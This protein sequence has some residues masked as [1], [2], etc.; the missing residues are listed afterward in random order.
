MFNRPICICCFPIQRKETESPGYSEKCEGC[1]CGK[2]M[3]WDLYDRIWSHPMRLFPAIPFYWLD[4]LIPHLS[5][6]MSNVFVFICFLDGSFGDEHVNTP[7][8]NRQPIERVQNW[9]HQKYS[10]SLGLRLHRGKGDWP[11]TVINAL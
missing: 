8:S 10:T 7:S 3:C 9:L 1:H 2:L 5:S 6:L 11:N 4:W